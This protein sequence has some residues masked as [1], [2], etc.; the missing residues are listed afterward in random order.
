MSLDVAKVVLEI[1][2]WDQPFGSMND[3]VYFEDKAVEVGLGKDD[4]EVQRVLRKWHSGEWVLIYTYVEIALMKSRSYEDDVPPLD[5][6]APML[7]PSA[8]P[9]AVSASCKSCKIK[10]RGTL[11]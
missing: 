5:P 7:D 11:D 4:V 1:L 3:P 8:R 2:E 9:K 10:S 6:S